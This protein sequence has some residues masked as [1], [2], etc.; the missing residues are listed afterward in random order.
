MACLSFRKSSKSLWLDFHFPLTL[1]FF[2]FSACGYFVDSLF[3]KASRKSHHHPNNPQFHENSLYQNRGEYDMP[4]SKL[5]RCNPALS[6]NSSLWKWLNC[7]RGSSQP[8]LKAEGLK[9]CLLSVIKIMLFGVKS[10]LM[11]KFGQK[12]KRG[13]INFPQAWQVDAFQ[14]GG[15]CLCV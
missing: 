11:G 10:S 5:V 6:A 13:L 12:R 9:L 8:L 4:D 1:L 7:S 15:A 2:P 3:W 14:S